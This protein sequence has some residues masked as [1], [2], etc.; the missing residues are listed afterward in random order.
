MADQR[1]ELRPGALV[2]IEG[3]PAVVVETA[4]TLARVQVGQSWPVW[5]PAAWCQPWPPRARAHVTP[6][7]T[8][9]QRECVCT[10]GSR[11]C[12]RAH[13]ALTPTEKASKP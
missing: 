7:E 2:W 1:A 13:E 8:H 6:S 11:I 9:T 12:A 4:G 3:L 5:L 10:G